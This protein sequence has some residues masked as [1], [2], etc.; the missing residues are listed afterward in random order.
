MV[1]ADLLRRRPDIRQAERLLAAQSARI[2]V[3]EA[4][5]YPSLSLSGVFGLSSEY[6]SDLGRWSSRTFSLGPSIDWNLLRGAVFAVWLK[7]KPLG[8]SSF[9][10]PMSKRF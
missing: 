1:P 2:G 6:F 7:R 10:R 9:A 4:Q 5:L 8:L 3:A